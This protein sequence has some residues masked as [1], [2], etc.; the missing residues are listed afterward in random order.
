MKKAMSKIK[1]CFL[2]MALLVSISL[3]SVK[4]YAYNVFEVTYWYSNSSSV[5]IW[6]STPTMT[7]K[8]LGNNSSFPFTTAYNHAYSKWT[9]AGMSI[10]NNGAGTSGNIAVHGG[11]RAQILAYNGEEIPSN[12]TGLTVGASTMYAYLNYNGITKNL[13]KQLSQQKVYIIDDDRTLNQYKKTTTHEVGHA[14]GWLGH[15][16]NSSD[17][18]Y[19]G[20]SSVTSLTI[21]DKRHIL[22]FY[23]DV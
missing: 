10:T 14:L 21:R 13:K 9:S 4:A 17:I 1:L 11:T 5:A 2:A 18:M 23:T 20:A 22:Q 8:N 16:S 19:S 3:N 12:Y 6:A 15:S 7:R